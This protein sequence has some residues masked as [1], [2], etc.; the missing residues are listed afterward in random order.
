MSFPVGKATALFSF[1]AVCLATPVPSFAQFAPAPGATTRVLVTDSGWI[2]QN[3][4]AA[5]DTTNDRYLV[6]FNTFGGLIKVAWLGADGVA[7][8]AP[9]TV[10]SGVHPR[11]RYEPRDN[12]FLLTYN[13]GGARKAVF[14]RYQAPDSVVVVTSAVTLSALAWQGENFGLA[15]YVPSTGV[16]LVPWWDAPGLPSQAFL[17]TLRIDG[18]MGPVIRLNPIAGGEAHEF[19]DVSC[20]ATECLAVGKYDN[21]GAMRRGLWGLWL[22]FNGTPTSPTFYFDVAT[23]LHDDAQVEYSPTQNVYVITWTEDFG[24]MKGLRVAPGATPDLS[25]FVTSAAL[26]GQSNF[27]YNSG[28]QTFGM[29][30]AGWNFDIYALQLDALGNPTGSNV[31]VSN[32]SVSDSR[33][34]LAANPEL[35]QFLAIYRQFPDALKGLL[36]QASPGSPRRRPTRP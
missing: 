7:I 12:A 34:A 18:S 8:G 32:A 35:G 24:N 22:D 10:A 4:D 21:D 14:L 6:V 33:T 31:P 36:L 20:G 1:L 25:E 27:L 9:M 26:G 23:S 2:G 13:G 15:T 29:V 30:T 17:R 28:T 5:Y 3:Y 19:P 11:L 16:Y